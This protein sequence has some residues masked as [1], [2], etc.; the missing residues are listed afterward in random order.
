MVMIAVM[1]EVCFFNPLRI[2]AN[3]EPPPSTTTF[4]PLCLLRYRETAWNTASPSGRKGCKIFLL[5]PIKLKY[6]QRE[7][8]PAMIQ[9]RSQSGSF[10]KEAIASTSTSQEVVVEK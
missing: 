10:L 3:P 2:D 5:N 9:K 6:M 4:G 7:P 1:F 8:N